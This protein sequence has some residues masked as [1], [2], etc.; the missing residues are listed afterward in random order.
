ML[1]LGLVAINSNAA[2]AQTFTVNRS[3]K[4]TSAPTR[5]SSSITTTSN[6]LNTT[7]KTPTV[8]TITPNTASTPISPTNSVPENNFT[9]QV[10]P[11]SGVATTQSPS[12]TGSNAAPINQMTTNSLGLSSRSGVR[13][14]RSLATSSSASFI[15]SNTSSVPLT[16][17]I[18]INPT[19]P[20]VTP[21]TTI[22]TPSSLE[23]VNVA[24]AEVLTTAI[25]EVV[26]AA[27][28]APEEVALPEAIIIAQIENSSFTP[29]SEPIP[30]STD[31]PTSAPTPFPVIGAGVAFAY[32]RRLRRRLKED[33][34]VTLGE[35]A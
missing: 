18:S 3:T 12:S 29:F 7:T 9:P 32:S 27:P 25:S 11:S 28:S 8:T 10:P 6:P 20:V 30:A 16:P 19:S 22:P 24:P 34:S 4:Q 5:S 31:T 21:N 2:V 33:Y 26:T 14:R 23:M 1:I 15:S 17:V 13:Q 35:F